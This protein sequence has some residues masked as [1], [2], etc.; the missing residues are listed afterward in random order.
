MKEEHRALGLGRDLQAAD[1]EHAADAQGWI[2][3]AQL[4]AIL[5]L[6]HTLPGLSLSAG[7]SP[8]PFRAVL[9]P[10]R[11]VVVASLVLGSNGGAQVAVTYCPRFCNIVG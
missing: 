7:S 3:K 1:C 9:H 8:L 4:K 2:G 6:L 11:L 10:A 5:T